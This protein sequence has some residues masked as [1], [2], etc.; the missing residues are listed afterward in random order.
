[1]FTVDLFRD[2]YRHMEWADATIWKSVR[3][4]A[5]DDERL[6]KLLRHIHYVQRA[7]LIL[8]R[9][10]ALSFRAPRD[11]ASLAEWAREYHRAV[12][13][14]VD[15]VTEEKLREPI[16]PPWIP[17]F[18]EAAGRKFQAATV[19]ESMFQVPAHSSYHRGQV[20]TRLRELGA[21][22]PLVDY[23]AWVWFGRPGAD[24]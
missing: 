19:G 14:Y 8:W 22:P 20:N 4:T 12:Q 16:V 15:T 23:I 18:E 17:E 11:A 5:A 9:G 1:M 2:L 24:W 10:E 21:T 3:A 6:I 13:P 7:F